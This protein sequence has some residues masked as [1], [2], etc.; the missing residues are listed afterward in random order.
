MYGP[1]TNSVIEIDN[2]RSSPARLPSNLWPEVSPE[3]RDMYEG[4]IP[5]GVE[6]LGA[7]WEYGRS[8]RSGGGILTP[9]SGEAPASHLS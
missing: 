8:M 2:A 3:C 1:D 5:I 4:V 9:I 7:D 6:A